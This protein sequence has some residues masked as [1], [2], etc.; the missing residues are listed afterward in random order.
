MELR[1]ERHW[2]DFGTGLLRNRGTDPIRRADQNSRPDAIGRERE[3]DILIPRSHLWDP[4]VSTYSMDKKMAPRLFGWP[5]A[6]IIATVTGELVGYLYRW[7][8]GD[9]QP[10]WL[11][12]AVADVR[13]EP[14]EH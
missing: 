6:R 8:N 2:T 5:V 10:A 13:Y 7:D 3:V 12:G 14:L 9:R 11:A 4:S 1:P